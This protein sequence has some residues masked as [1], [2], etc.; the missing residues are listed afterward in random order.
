[1]STATEKEKQ[2]GLRLTMGQLIRRLMKEDNLPSEAVASLEQAL[3]S[4]N[5]LAHGY[6]LNVRSEDV[7]RELQELL[8]LEELFLVASSALTGR[9]P[10]KLADGESYFLHQRDVVMDGGGVQRIYFF[11]RLPGGGAVDAHPAGYPDS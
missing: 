10:H 8:R 9:F 3:S 11:A 5:K 1:M 6:F 4:R 2:R 7:Q